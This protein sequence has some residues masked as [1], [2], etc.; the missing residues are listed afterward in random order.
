MNERMTK[1]H[2]FGLAGGPNPYWVGYDWNLALQ[3]GALATGQNYSG[4]YT[5]V[6]TEMYLTVNHEI[7][8]KEMALGMNQECAD[9][10]FQDQVDWQALGWSGD[11]TRGG[12]RP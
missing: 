10:H 8:P 3:D 5:F 7:A 6:D 9:C 11:P 1:I 4:Q 12:T 2:L